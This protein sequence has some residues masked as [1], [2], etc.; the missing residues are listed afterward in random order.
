MSRNK[1][2]PY[3]CYT[4]IYKIDYNKLYSQGIKIILFDL[5]NTISKYKEKDP[6]IEAKNLM[7]ELK[8]IGFLVIV[9]SNNNYKRIQRSLDGLKVMGFSKAKKPLKFGYKRVIKYLMTNALMKSTD[10]ILA[11]GDQIITDVWGANRMNI[12]CILVNPIHQADEKWYTR[13]NRRTENR[14]IEKM[15]KIDYNIYKKIKESRGEQFE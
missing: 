8:D 12:R 1:F 13:L 10:E 3:D 7:Q 11:I 2:I 14:I 6:S 4:D 5:D 15:K 9:L